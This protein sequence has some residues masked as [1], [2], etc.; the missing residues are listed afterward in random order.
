MVSHQG[1][2]KSRSC[3][4]SHGVKGGSALTSL[5]PI[6]AVTSPIV[7]VTC[8]YLRRPVI[9]GRSTHDIKSKVFCYAGTPSNV[10]FFGISNNSIEAPLDDA[11][12]NYFPKL[13][14]LLISENKFYGE[15]LP[16]RSRQGE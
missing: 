8:L 7:A 14:A 11:L 10:R 16:S 13:E 9:M 4:A 12:C 6:V 15:F 5:A 2:S 1:G 3:A